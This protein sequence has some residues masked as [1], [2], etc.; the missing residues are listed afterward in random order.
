MIYDQT[1]HLVQNP[2]VFDPGK[3]GI[4]LTGFFEAAALAFLR[5]RYYWFP[6]HPMGLAFQN[7]AGT[8]IYWFSL[9]LVWIAKFLLLR[10]GGVRAYRAGKPFFYGMGI[11]YVAAVVLSGVVDVIWF[12]VE[13]HRVHD[14]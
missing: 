4:W 11:G 8:S 14:W 10:Y 9:F 3:W 12:P 5:A 2:R 13:G 6:L 1:A 7:T